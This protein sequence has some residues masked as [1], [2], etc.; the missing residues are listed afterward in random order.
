MTNYDYDLFVIGGGSGGV[1]AARIAATHG[2]RVGI[3]EEFRYGGTCVIRG[4]VPKKLFVFAS[5]FSEAFED[6]AGFGWDVGA[7][8]FNW[9]KLRD[10]TAA[11]VARLEQI[12]RRNLDNSGVTLFDSRAELD[13]AHTVRLTTTGETVTADKILI[14]TGATPNLHDGLEGGEH[15]I[16]SNEVFDLLEFPKRVLVAGAGYIAVEFAGI[17]HGIGAETSIIYRGDKILRGFD[18]DVRDILQGTYRDK[19]IEIIT[20]TVFSKIEKKPDGLHCT[21]TNGEVRVVDHVMMAIGRRPL[22]DNLG[23]EKAGVL[24]APDRSI[25]VDAYSR[26]NVE[27]IF[28]VGDV[29]NRV[30]LTPVAIRE[31]HAFADTEFGGMD[32]TADHETIPTAVFSQ[33]EIGTVGLNEAEARAKYANV[34]VFKASF[35]AMKNIIAERDERTLMKLIVDGD[36]DRVVGCHI[37][38]PDAGEMSQLAGVAVKMGATKADFDNTV[39]VHPTA[40]EELVT[41]RTPVA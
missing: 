8:Q 19:G 2:A 24:L 30:Q 32:R 20:N 13:N 23:L 9:E 25:A 17:F 18:E 16:T 4:C 38:G 21:L 14:A 26:T 35:R 37:F 28:A 29:T 27:N 12:Y 39:A 10:R 22:T 33:P 31:G 15:T 1:R 41:M 40:A 3:A 11:E 34:V 5:T 7:P 6:A 36:T